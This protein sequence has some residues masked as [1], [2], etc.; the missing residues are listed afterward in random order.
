MNKKRPT[1][2]DAPPATDR[3]GLPNR[4]MLSLSDAHRNELWSRSKDEGLAPS[5]YARLILL[6]RRAALSP[7]E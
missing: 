1:R 4:V 7:A 6:G 5:T 3:T 2:R